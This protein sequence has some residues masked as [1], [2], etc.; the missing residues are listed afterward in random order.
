MRQS[1]ILFFCAVSLFVHA[2][3]LSDILRGEYNAQTLSPAEQDS[4]L[5]GCG[6]H[7]YLLRHD[8]EEKIFRHSYLANYYIYDTLR[9]T[10]KQIGDGPIRDAIMSDNGKYVAFGRDNKLYLQKLDYGTCV[11]I[12]PTNEDEDPKNDDILEGVTDWLYEEEF[13]ATHVMCFSPD[14]KLL[15]FVRTKEAEVPTFYWQEFLS[16]LYTPTLQALRY[17]KAGQQNPIVEV[18]VYDI[19]TKGIK[20]M[21]IP[22]LEGAYIPR[23]CWVKGTDDTNRLMVLRLNRDQNELEVIECNPRST[24]CNVW[25]REKSKDH[26]IDYSL[27]DEWQWLSDGRV[28]VV[29][30]KSGWRQA[31]LYSAQGQEQKQ[32]TKDGVDV[33][34]VYGIDEKTWT[35]YYQQADQPETRDVYALSLKAKGDKLKGIR[36]SMGDG[37]NTANFST[38][39]T[40]AIL[41]CESD[42]QPIR[43]QL[44]TVKGDKVSTIKNV[45]PDN[46]KIKAQ[47]DALSLPVKEWFT[48]KTERG[49]VLHGWKLA[50]AGANNRPVVMTQYSGPA[51]QRVVNRWKKTWDY[52]LA[53]MGYVVV[54]VDGRGT[55][56]R[57]RQWRNASY[58]NLGEK[59][60]EDQ[61]STA[62][63]VATW[64]MVDGNRIGMV[65][66]SYGGFQVLRT[67]SSNDNNNGNKPLIKAGIAIAPVTD[68]R[69][70]DSA[71]TERYMRRVQVNEDGYERAS[72]LNKAA[73]LR[74]EI[75][76]VHGLADDNVHAQN[77]LL[78]SEKLVEAGVQFEEQIYV[79][80]NHQLRKRSNREHL[81]RRLVK[82]LNDKL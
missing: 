47:W 64:P 62:K 76:L 41:S 51:S 71:Y 54:C 1:F 75:L 48:F 60:A 19:A 81:H 74:G 25:Y 13:G 39:Y 21:D 69:L 6:N 37:W 30:E 70:Y 16:D 14:N 56:A 61:I 67:M 65:G 45:G 72:L 63:H 40:L 59:E 22:E 78:Y 28:L 52:A 5:N 50:R 46:N 9:H 58:M 55:D 2:D 34:A 80:D 27:F 31:Y 79:D 36:I 43:Y 8:N 12:T 44:A 57:G 82:F 33:T 66:W 3:V 53:E 7:R 20:I 10:N 68:W 24:V 32:L 26:Y 23:I 35:L 42:Q 38:N 18:C 29:S 15:A 73:N 49:D 4:I 11:A 77:T 17:P